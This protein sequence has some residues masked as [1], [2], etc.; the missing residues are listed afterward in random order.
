MSVRASIS[1]E[2]AAEAIRTAL[3][4]ANPTEQQR[5][6][7]EAPLTHGVINAGAGSGKTAVMTARIVHLIATEAVEPDRILG[8]TFT[9]K[10]AEELGHRVRGAMQVLGL[11]LDAQPTVMTYN[12]FAATFLSD[13]GLFAGYEPSSAL[14]TDGQAFQM[15]WEALGSARYE[16]LEVR[17]TYPVGQARA[18]ASEVANHLV[19][20]DALEA[21][22]R[23]ILAGT[24]ADSRADQ[25]KRRTSQRRLDLASAVRRF[26][27][28][29]KVRQRIDY[30][31]QIRIGYE[32]AGI[33]EVRAAFRERFGVVL[34]DEFQDTNIA[35]AA[36]L[37]RLTLSDAEGPAVIAV[38][39]PW[40]NIY[41]W[42][43][44]NIRNILMF[45]QEFAVDGEPAPRF[46]LATNFRSASRILEVANTILERAPEPGEIATPL[47]PRADAPEGIVEAHLLIDQEA[48]AERIASRVDALIASGV[49]AREVAILSRSRRLF[50]P[51]LTRLQ[52]LGH[53]VEPLGLGG[54][55][56]TPEIVDVLS[57]LRATTDRL[58]NIALARVLTGGRWRISAIDLALLARDRLEAD[59][60]RRDEDPSAERVAYSLSDAIEE[61]EDATS[62][63]EEARKRLLRFRPGFQRLR[64]AHHLRLDEL[65]ELAIDALG[66]PLEID[67]S[68][69]PN[70]IIV[71]RNLANLVELAS[72]F[73]PIDGEASVPSFLAWLDVVA[74]VNEPLEVA[75]PSAEDSIKL[76]TIHQAKGLEFDVVVL[77]GLAGAATA[78]SKLFP[79]T[80][81][82]GDPVARPQELPIE[83]R[84]D[85]ESLPAATSTQRAVK[86]AFLEKALREEHRL[87]YVAVTRARKHLIATAAHWYYPSEAKDD[88]LKNPHGPSEFFDLI[89]DHPATSQVERVDQPVENPLTRVRDDAATRWPAPARREHA[90]F[91]D[92]IAA[93]V[94]SARAAA[95]ED[96]SLFPTTAE[97]A[98]VPPATIS[99][100]GFVTYA[101]C[102]KRYFW[103]FIRPLP[104]RSNVKARVGT[105]VHDWIAQRHDPQLTLL[106]PDEFDASAATPSAGI[107]AS[108]RDRFS[109]S[110]FAD[111]VP[112]A[113]EHPF[114]LS[115]DGVILQGRIDAIFEDA[116]GSLEIVDW[117]TGRAPIEHDAED[118][119][120][121]LY[122]LAVLRIFRVDASALRASFVYLGGEEIVER[123]VELGDE[124]ALEAALRGQLD[125]IRGG[126]F[127]STP[128]FRCRSC[129]FLH[130][131]AEG[132]AAEASRRA[133]AAGPADASA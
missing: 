23:A 24:P 111:R 42:R 41:A 87:F 29:K 20:L 92:G 44:A 93:A 132:T 1:R 96:P 11:G 117:K 21:Y 82:S 69:S 8:L 4:G 14:I 10:A 120:M 127:D 118:W 107:V 77:C 37:R 57:L 32:L 55:L 108:L 67:A 34:L 109:S 75:Q 128:S 48:E 94:R 115:L 131:C 65:V 17:T 68:A 3:K 90:R 130:L 124:A 91:P 95:S 73:Q 38:G 19:D 122:A 74:E 39:D 129:D 25:T 106:D 2:L 133:A 89:A 61:V 12:A 51:I 58:E 18:L 36:L 49:P 72:E 59:Q 30:D 83:F 27:E 78:R 56:E 62:I 47:V 110:R 26:H 116:D 79:S 60:R 80:R 126:A 9:N 46:P 28:L 88:S 54:L 35:Q 63:S 76:M 22:D 52:D 119:Q 101:G 33:P 99:A 13:H 16:H 125:Q 45:P 43:G 66:L 64:A 71:R 103:S 84:G 121:T 123:S 53:A 97:L 5:A 105:I 70:A 31:D 50:R 100:T 113:V 86:D 81:G 7:I 15:M 104:R 114:I 40:Q 98:P 112:R 85:R 102:P 6:I